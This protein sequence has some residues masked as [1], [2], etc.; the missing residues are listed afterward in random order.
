MN[1]SRCNRAVGAAVTCVLAAI[2]TTPTSLFAQE[3]ADDDGLTQVVI[4]GSFIKRPADRPQPLTVLGSEQL[5]DTQRNS[6]ADSLKDLPQNVGSLATVNSQGGGFNA[7][8]T[9]TATINLRGLGAG[10]SLVLLNGGRQINDGGFGFVDVNNLAPAI[11]IDRVEVLT[12]G[13]SALY[14]AD[15]VAGVVNFITKSKFDGFQLKAD[16]T[17]IE[18]TTHARPDINVGLLWGGQ[19]D[20]TRVVAGA[21]YQTT[22]MLLTDDRY[23]ADRLRLGL[24]SGFGNPATFQYRNRT[25]VQPALPVSAIPDPLCGSSQLGG[26]P[27]GLAAGVPVTTGTPS[28]QLYNA[29]GRALQPQSTRINGL[30]TI[31]H[32]FSDSVTGDFEMGF[33]RTRY[34]FQFGY[35]TPAT[36]TT[37]LFPL[38]PADNPGAVATARRFPGFL[39]PLNGQTNIS[40]Y[41]YRGRILAPW[42]NDGSSGD[43]RTTG[44]DTYRV[45]GRLNGKFG[46]S[47]WDWQLGFSDSWNDTNFLGH[48]TVI[49]RVGLALNG[50]GGPRCAFTPATDPTGA[51][52]GVDTCKFWDPFA[53]AALVPASDPAAND[54]VVTNWLLGNRT[55]HDAGELRTYSALTTGKLWDM[56]GGTTGLAVGVERRELSFSQQWDEGSKQLG[57]YGFNGAFAQSDFSGSN[58]TQAAFAELVTYPLRTLEVQLAGRYE[59]T[60]YEAAGNFD[61][62]NPKLGLLW[63]P[64]QGLFVR[65]SAGTSF[66]APSPAQIFAQSSGGTSAQQIGGDTINARGLLT[67]NPN[68]KPERSKNWNVGVTWDVTQDFTAELNYFNIRFT[69]YITQEVTQQILTADLADGFIT[70]PHIVLNPGAP[71]EVCEVTGRWRPGQGVRP[72]TCMSGNDIL[73]FNTTYINQGFLRTSGVDYDFRYRLRPESLGLQFSFRLYGTYTREYQLQQGGVTYDGVGKYNDSTFGVPMPEYTANLT[74]G[75]TAGAHALTATVRYLPSMT[76][77]VPIPASNAGTESKSFTTLDLLYRFQLP[78]NDR[79]SVSAAIRNVTNEEDPIAGGSQLTGFNNTYSSFGRVFRVGVDY[80]F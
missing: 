15:A 8:N 77:Q 4:T 18:D 14:G 52:R 66:Q 42:V 23:D 20:T 35:V 27:S 26:G 54:P 34:T 41:L 78:W 48:D 37:S 1:Q 65:A 9:P 60:S 70:D 5:D 36:T 73:Q 49:N 19:S 38:V 43:I 40:G 3:A 39:H 69:D 64:V 24:S 13:S 16:F 58:V 25:G 74:A 7:G 72:A 21:E 30:T 22:E 17:R 55:T 63:T 46:G 44:Q 79:S 56:A 71:N 2:A 53:I 51:R 45:A 62:V 11:M 12:D 31:S 29:L 61:K 68:L 28:C 47:G 6:V 75:V 57:Y 10:A 50:Y 80:R 76:L 59:R 67:G 32:D 33:A